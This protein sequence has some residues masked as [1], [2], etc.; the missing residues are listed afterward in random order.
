MSLTSQ[1]QPCSGAAGHL[2]QVMVAR[3]ESQEYQKVLG[4]S[5]PTT[6]SVLA[7][8]GALRMAKQFPAGC[9]QLIPHYQ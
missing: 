1:G 3:A 7:L 8:E 6:G 5:Q 2:E 9:R 4:L